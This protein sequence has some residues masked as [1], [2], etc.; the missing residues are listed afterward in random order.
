MHPILFHCAFLRVKLLVSAKDLKQPQRSG[1]LRRWLRVRLE[2]WKRRK[3]I[4]ALNALDD[5]T[6]RD[7]GIQRCHIKRFGDSLTGIDSRISTPT[8]VPTDRSRGQSRFTHTS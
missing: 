1:R 3:T 2:Q 6:L 8:G 7:I 4:A 5:R